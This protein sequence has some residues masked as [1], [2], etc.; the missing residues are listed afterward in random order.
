MKGGREREISVHTLY[1]INQYSQFCYNATY[2]FLKIMILSLK[3][4]GLGGKWP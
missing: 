2:A 4:Q 3:P 1:V